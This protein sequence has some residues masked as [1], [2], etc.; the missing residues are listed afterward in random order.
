MSRTLIGLIVALIIVAGAATGWAQTN[1]TAVR[2]SDNTLWAMTC[3]GTSNCSAWT[4]ISGLFSE[5]PTLTW[6]PA[7]D[8][9]IMIG[10]GN[11][12]SS[13]WR[14]TFNANGTFNNDWTKITGA[15]PSPVAVAAGN[16][17]GEVSLVAEVCFLYKLQGLSV[18][19]SLQSQCPRIIF[20]T[21]AR[22]TGSMLGGL[23]GADSI[24]QVEAN[25]ANLKG[26]YKAWLSD[27][28]V[29]ASSRMVHSATPY[30]NTRAEVFVNSWAD[31]T[32]G[33]GTYAH[34]YTPHGAVPSYDNSSACFNAS[35]CP[36]AWTNTNAYG[37]ISDTQHS[38]NN[39]IGGS[40][41]AQG[42]LGNWIIEG[43]PTMWTLAYTTSCCYNY[44]LY[45]LEQ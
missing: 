38:C 31:L 37:E 13:I 30:W 15:S 2:H 3:D 28:Q 21:D 36:Y 45:C 19:Q 40:C 39:W 32:S 20:L 1:L 23:A 7:L 9:Y 14:S 44:M 4:K 5:Q 16:F 26:T 17:K 29:S 25:L 33:N 10:I 35:T 12:G 22:Y 8:K 24:C 41:S 27:S 43:Y 18:P 34:A 11:N 6:D 42:T